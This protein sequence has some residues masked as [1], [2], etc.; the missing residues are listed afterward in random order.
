MTHVEMVTLLQAR[1]IRSALVLQALGAVPRAAF[2]PEAQ[3]AQAYGDYPL[4]I[5]HQQTI[6]QP[7]IVALMTEA[8]EVQ[9]G[10]RV[11]EIGTGSGY[12]AAVLAEMGLEVYSIERIP[13]LHQTAQQALVEAGYGDVHCKLGDGSRGWPEHAPYAGILVTAA[14]AEVPPAL[15]EQLADGGRLVIPVGL[16][17]HPQELWQITR[18][19]DDFR[20]HSLG[21]V[22]FVPFIHDRV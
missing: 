5:G 22:A 10:E 20:W 21:G 9:P 19:G 13:A 8:L 7:Y 3:R 6:S 4:P 14:P 16:P 15:L 12:Q 2:V 1:G 11:L 17:H 18:R